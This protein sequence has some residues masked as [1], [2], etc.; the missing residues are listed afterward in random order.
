MNS[1]PP[2]LIRRGTRLLR[3]SVSLN[4]SFFPNWD[5]VH[6]LVPDTPSPFLCKI[7]ETKNLICDY[8]LDL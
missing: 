1:G 7:L 6:C 2:R 8:A 4:C 5:G 3:S